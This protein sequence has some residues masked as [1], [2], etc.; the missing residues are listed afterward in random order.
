M[1]MR[2]V[3]TRIVIKRHVEDLKRRSSAQ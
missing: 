3:Y 1:T 2:I